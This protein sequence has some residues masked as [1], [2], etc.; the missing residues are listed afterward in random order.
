MANRVALIAAL[1]LPLMSAA[2]HAQTDADRAAIRVAALDYIE[3]WYTGDAARM[4]RAIHP[5]LA[6]RIVR[7]DARGGSSLG[8]QDAMTLLQN[9]R[10]GGGS[11]TPEARRPKDV[12]ILDVYE[13][14]A[15]VKIVAADW[16]DYLH[17]A[18]WDGGWKIVNVL[19]ET[20][21]EAA[22]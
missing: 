22:R 14:S 21:P 4:E 19:W 12:I 3:G 20:K 5:E 16:I 18:R 11:K 8:Q 17:L 9:T 7:R 6:K 2:A 13:N 1:L 10:A 15:S